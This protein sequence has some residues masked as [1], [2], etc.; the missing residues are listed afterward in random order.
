[1]VNACTGGCVV[2]VSY[3]LSFF[4]GRKLSRIP[5][6]HIY[7]YI[8]LILL[9]G[10]LKPILSSQNIIINLGGAVYYNGIRYH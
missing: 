7:M 4:G 1:M 6:L 3:R 5:Y 9:Y 10:N 8:Y 2:A